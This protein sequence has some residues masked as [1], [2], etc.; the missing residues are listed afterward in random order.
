[1]T[2][3]NWPE[4]LTGLRRGETQAFEQL[5]TALKTPVYTIALRI[6]QDR[7]LA[8]DVLQEVFLRLYQSPP[9]ENVRN[10]RAYVFRMVRNLSID[11]LRARPALAGEESLP[12]QAAPPT[13]DTA[14]RLDI[15]SALAALALRDREIVT[16]HLNA[17]L[18]FREIA[19][20]LSLPL[21]TAL[22]RYQKAIG[23]LQA[24][25]K[26]GEF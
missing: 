9:G 5:Y 19:G 24:I 4:A 14:L 22:W 2:E 23:Q 1:M 12:E 21:G 11:T 20:V 25:L 3:I 17:G 6:L 8:E 10:P 18:T 15:E 26:D 16:L 7:A 13:E